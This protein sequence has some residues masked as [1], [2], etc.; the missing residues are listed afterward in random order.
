[1][2]VFEIASGGCR[3][4][5]GRWQS[6]GFVGGYEARLLWSCKCFA[7]GLIWR[8]QRRC[9]KG[10]TPVRCQAQR[11][12]QESLP[13]RR[14]VNT[15]IS[16]PTPTPTTATTTTTTSTPRLGQENVVRNISI[17]PSGKP[18]NAGVK[19]F[20]AKTPG[21]KAPKTPFKV[22]LNDENVTRQA[23]K[24]NGK[25]NENLL[26]TSTKGGKLDDNAFVTPAGEA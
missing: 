24:A 4:G 12:A 11:L 23:G 26:F 8:A 16:A 22:P 5:D 3:L 2:C 18:L 10:P 6:S 7:G 13:Q 19:A 21:L 15:P 9:R 20:G 17:G 1:V 25:G 14:R